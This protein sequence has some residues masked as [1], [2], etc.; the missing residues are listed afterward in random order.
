[1]NKSW[2]DNTD[3]SNDLVQAIHKGFDSSAPTNGGGEVHI[4]AV[5]VQTLRFLDSFMH[6]AFHIDF[7]WS[8]H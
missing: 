4:M 6:A 3:N 8:V 5:T 1:M 2:N 7:K